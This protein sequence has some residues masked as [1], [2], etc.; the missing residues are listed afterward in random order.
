VHREKASCD[1][2]MGLL[3]TS[4]STAQCPA[5]LSVLGLAQKGELFGGQGSGQFGV[6]NRVSPTS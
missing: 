6:I 3:H 4:W 1:C 5:A 2:R